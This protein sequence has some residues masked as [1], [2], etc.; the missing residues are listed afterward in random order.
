MPFKDREKA[1]QYYRDYDEKNKDKRKKWHK[2]YHRLHAKEILEKTRRWNKMHPEYRKAY[3]RQYYLT[4]RQEMLEQKKNWT[5]S[6]K[7]EILARYGSCCQCCGEKNMEFLAIDHIGGG[8]NKH[9]REL[10]IN[11]GSGL[12]MWLIKNN[13]P[14]GFRVLCHNCNQALAHYGYCPHRK[15]SS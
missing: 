12:Y 3:N 4:H 1:L 14:S 13:F 8:G 9:R 15:T 7:L 10:K 6:R 5:Y 11:N 2:N